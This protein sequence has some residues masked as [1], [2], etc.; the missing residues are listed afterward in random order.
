[1]KPCVLCGCSEAKLAFKPLYIV[2]CCSCGFYYRDTSVPSTVYKELSKYHDLLDDKLLLEA[3]ERE[4]NKRIQLVRMFL[5]PPATIYEIG[6]GDGTLLKQLDLEGFMVTGIEPNSHMVQEATRK[7]LHVTSGTLEENTRNIETQYDAVM[8]FHVL[9]HLNDPKTALDFIHHILQTSGILLL[10]VPSLDS[11]NFKARRWRANWAAEEHL[12][13]F[14]RKTLTNLLEQTGFKI[15]YHKRRNWDED[16]QTFRNN[17]LRLPFITLLYLLYRRIKEKYEPFALRGFAEGGISDKKTPQGRISRLAARLVDIFNRGDS[18]F[19]V[20]LKRDR[21]PPKAAF[22]PYR[23]LSTFFEVFLL[24]ILAL[25]YFPITFLRRADPTRILVIPTPKL[26]D[27]ISQLPFLHK[28]RR[29]F[30]NA[31]IAVLL[32]NPILANF[33][34]PHF[35]KTIVSNGLSFVSF[36]KTILLLL[37]E[38]F[39]TV[40]ILPWSFR[41]DLLAYF[42][43]IPSRYGVYSKDIPLLSQLTRNI[44]ISTKVDYR[45]GD[46][47]TSVYLSILGSDD[48]N[49]KR[50]VCIQKD[51]MKSM[52]SKTAQF[53]LGTKKVAGVLVGCGNS[54]KL[55]NTE[56]WAK[57]CDFL[58]SAGFEVCMIGS[59]SDKL[60]AE[61]VQ[62]GARCPLIDTT[63][64]FTLPELAAFC[65]RLSIVIGVDSG[66]LYLANALGIPVVDIAGPVDPREQLP[67]ENSVI[68]NSNAGCSP[69]SHVM[70]TETRC[71]FGTRRCLE[72]LSAEHV[73]YRLEEYLSRKISTDLTQ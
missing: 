54:L 26:G 46:F 10:E 41:L 58:K 57:V 16:Y 23:S 43:L 3:R 25:F 63:G 6:V 48:Y 21:L 64:L 45:T 69:C 52:E 32:L 19:V 53:E 56:K 27:F 34:P 66:P 70:A 51:W 7:G 73:I 60:L 14:T 18:L 2:R 12:S 29:K 4:A 1:M 35:N 65:Q 8:M 67:E 38:R 22:S 68:I 44:F 9:E 47:S 59:D 55:W 17:F 72:E 71:R 42:S 24:L 28:I 39:G 61:R 31:E 40:Y 30:P 36:V 5:D 15:L 50:D 49:V 62:L 20:A 11:P 13:Y 33:V 37:K